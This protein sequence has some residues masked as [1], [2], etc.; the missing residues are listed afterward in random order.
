MLRPLGVARDYAQLHQ[1]LRDR[2]EQLGVNLEVLGE[3]SRLSYVP[4]LLSPVP[5][6]GAAPPGG[7]R[8][9]GRTIGAANLGRGRCRTSSGAC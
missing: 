1:A 8:G 7:G 9:H 5:I 6:G 2:R 3:I 4:K